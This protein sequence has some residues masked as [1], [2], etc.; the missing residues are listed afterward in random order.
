MKCFESAI[1]LRR[2]ALGDEHPSVADMLFKV[3]VILISKRGLYRNALKFHNLALQIRLIALK[4]DDP[5]I[6]ASYKALGSISYERAEFSKAKS[7]YRQAFVVDEKIINE[8]STPDAELNIASSLLGLGRVECSEGKHSEA[9]TYYTQAQKLQ[10]TTCTDNNIYLARTLHAI[11]VSNVRKGSTDE[12]MSFY[13][14][15]LRLQRDCLPDVHPD[16]AKSLS[17]IGVVQAS[18]G[19][20]N[21]A[22]ITFEKALAMQRMCLGNEHVEVA[23]T[24]NNLGIALV[25][26]QLSKKAIELYDQAKNMIERTLKKDHPFIADI[27][28]NKANAHFQCDE[29]EGSIDCFNDAFRIYRVCGL[30]NDHPSIVRA[31]NLMSRVRHQENLTI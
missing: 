30:P 24:L 1:N 7:F 26:Q 9:L 25:S 13:R 10:N 29:Y 4:D 18:T 15:A 12:G 8:S 19:H 3:G 14:E 17:S 27:V 16:V 23:R 21:E 11:G 5:A 2:D 20:I 22:I 31:L 28:V 6:S